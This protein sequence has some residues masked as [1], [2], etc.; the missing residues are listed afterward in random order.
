MNFQ[1]FICALENGSFKV[2]TIYIVALIFCLALSLKVVLQYDLPACCP[3]YF[4]QT[5]LQSSDKYEENECRTF[6]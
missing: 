2:A 3:K 1:V 6:R 4:T 5:V